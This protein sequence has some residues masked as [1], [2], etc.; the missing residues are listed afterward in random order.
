MNARDTSHAVSLVPAQPANSIWQTHGRTCLPTILTPHRTQ[1]TP[2]FSHRP[3]AFSP[4]MYIV[5]NLSRLVT[6]STNVPSQLKLKTVL[7]DKAYILIYTRRPATLPLGVSVQPVHLSTST[8]DTVAPAAAS[9]GDITFGVTPKASEPPVAGAKQGVSL[10]LPD[11][12][13]ARAGTVA[14][15]GGFV[16]DS[17]GRS[18]EA[19]KV[20]ENPPSLSSGVL[21]IQPVPPSTPFTDTIIAAVG[22]IDDAVAFSCYDPR[23]GPRCIRQVRVTP[24]LA[25]GTGGSEALEVMPVIIPPAPATEANPPS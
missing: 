14:G 23:V 19:V 9:T 20:N 17:A 5:V 22:T 21:N 1:Y 24:C 18:D 13:G 4:T 16:V 3:E 10:H 2:L 11:A 15:K 8:A 25:P 6:S 12:V 7:A